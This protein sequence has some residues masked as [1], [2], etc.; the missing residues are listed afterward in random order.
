MDYNS[1]GKTYTPDEIREKLTK[2]KC[3]KCSKEFYL[4]DP[5][6]KDKNQFVGKTYS[7]DGIN[8]GVILAKIEKCPYCFASKRYIVPIFTEK[9]KKKNKQKEEKEKEQQREKRRKV[10]NME[11]EKIFDKVKDLVKDL[12]KNLFDDKI[13]PTQFT[14]IFM[15]LSFNI[16]KNNSDELPIDWVYYRKLMLNFVQD[17][18]E[19]YSVKIDCEQEYENFSENIKENNVYNSLNAKYIEDDKYA[20]RDLEMK[21][22]IETEFERKRMQKEHEQLT[23]IAERYEKQALTSDENDL[24]KELRRNVSNI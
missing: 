18:L 7:D 14:K 10:A 1:S 4:I 17:I 15:D 3:G 22:E 12:R 16:A 6:F 23:K 13:T 24:K 20:L 11:K 5:D 9:Q 2:Y 8:G 19:S 21:T